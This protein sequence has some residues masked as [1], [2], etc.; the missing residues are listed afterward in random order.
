[1]TKQQPRFPIIQ[2]AQN[3]LDSKQVW[4]MPALSWLHYPFFQ[5]DQPLISDKDHFQASETS[6]EIVLL[7]QKNSVCILKNTMTPLEKG[8]KKSTKNV[9]L[10]SF[11]I[12]FEGSKEFGGL[13]PIKFLQQV[14]L[15]DKHGNRAANQQT[16][17][18]LAGQENMFEQWPLQSS[19]WP[20]GTS[21]SCHKLLVT[22]PL[23]VCHLMLAWTWLR[24]ALGLIS[25]RWKLLQFHSPASCCC[26]VLSQHLPHSALLLF[27]ASL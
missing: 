7:I 1:M 16:Q 20:Q 21:N 11:A 9:T 12:P 26:S 17:N 18:F 23:L 2:G 5:K 13:P 3:L 4:L 25:Q 24:Y 19:S 22:Q 6:R 14:H 15:C 8:E 10:A 27:H